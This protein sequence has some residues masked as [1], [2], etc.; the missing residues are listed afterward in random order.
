MDG[1][2][3]CELRLGR[4]GGERRGGWLAPAGGLTSP[5]QTLWRVGA[6]RQDCIEC[7]S[8]FRDSQRRRSKAS[9]TTARRSSEESRGQR[10]ETFIYR[11]QPATPCPACSPVNEL[12]RSDQSDA[13]TGHAM[14]PSLLISIVY[15]YCS[16]CFCLGAILLLSCQEPST[17]LLHCA[18]INK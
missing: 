9:V 1:G 11:P 5:S 6:R 8:C 15:C 4:V 13:G 2:A 12:Q 17:C 14:P 18:T 7:N 3:G 16:L 10:D